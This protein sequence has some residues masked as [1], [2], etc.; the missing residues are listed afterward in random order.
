[1]IFGLSRPMISAPSRQKLAGEAEF[2]PFRALFEP[3]RPRPEYS[4]HFRGHPSAPFAPLRAPAPTIPVSKPLFRA[5]SVPFFGLQHSRSCSYLPFLGAKGGRRDSESHR[6]A[7]VS[8][9]RRQRLTPSVETR[10]ARR[11]RRFS[12]S[13]EPGRTLKRCTQAIRARLEDLLFWGR[14]WRL[15]QVPETNNAARV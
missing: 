15:A 2:A 10:R 3:P 8:G 11:A 1:M 13:L 14:R 5:T 6:T 7:S 12:T 9:G 4:R